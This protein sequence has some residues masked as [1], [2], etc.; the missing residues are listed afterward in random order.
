VPK[1][2]KIIEIE[3]AVTRIQWILT[4]TPPDDQ[5]GVLKREIAKLSPELRK[6]VQGPAIMGANAQK[7]Q[8]AARSARYKFLERM[9]VLGF[10][11][12]FVL[13]IVLM[14]A[15]VP[16][17]TAFQ[18]FV[19]RTVLS[20]AAGCAAAF[21]PGFLKVEPAKAVRAGGAM[22]VFAAVYFLNPARL[23]GLL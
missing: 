13:L 6:A 17:P 18:Y 21:I 10:A 16:N 2:V 12:V 19:F 4:E 1:S 15:F 7:M 11:T 5:I 20:L 22:A 9:A 23:A 14:A 8:N 3:K